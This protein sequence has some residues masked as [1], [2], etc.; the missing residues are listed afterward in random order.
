MTSCKLPRPPLSWAEPGGQ[1]E[2]PRGHQEVAATLLPRLMGC[3]EVKRELSVALPIQR[4][5][6]SPT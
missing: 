2:K 5:L 3:Q 4:V 1:L 6:V